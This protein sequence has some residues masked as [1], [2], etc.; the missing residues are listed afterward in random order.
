VP[1]DT[2]VTIPEALPTVARAVLE[3]VHDPPEVADV[4]EVL[5]LMHISVV[6]VIVAGTGLTVISR[7]L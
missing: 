3:Q 2:P 7:V 1:A 4:S 6:P 5:P